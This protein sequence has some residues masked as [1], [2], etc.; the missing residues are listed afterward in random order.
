M[1][2]FGGKSRAETVDT[3]FQG[4]SSATSRRGEILRH[5][6]PTLVSRMVCFQRDEVIIL[7][8]SYHL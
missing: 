2:L 1:K 4:S 3:F 5:I 6:D 8:F 7:I